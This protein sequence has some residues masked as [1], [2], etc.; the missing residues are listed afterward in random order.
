V[1]VDGT[2]EGAT[3]DAVVRVD[4]IPTSPEG[5]DSVLVRPDVT[6][7]FS[8]SLWYSTS[9]RGAVGAL[10]GDDCR[11]GRRRYCSL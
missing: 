9:I 8:A 4:V 1:S 7:R 2:V 10:F 11:R 5:G 3:A 6:G